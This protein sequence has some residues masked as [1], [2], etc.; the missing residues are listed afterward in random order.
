VMHCPEEVGTN[1]SYIQ[2]DD[3]RWE[4]VTCPECGCVD[5][6]DETIHET[7]CVLGVNP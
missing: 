5:Q 3:V 2:N 1:N 7:S 4:F 6:G